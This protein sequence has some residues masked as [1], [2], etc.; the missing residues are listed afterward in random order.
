MHSRAGDANTMLTP[1]YETVTAIERQVMARRQRHA[2]D[3]ITRID[4]MDIDERKTKLMAAAAE[5]IFGRNHAKELNRL[6]EKHTD[7]FRGM[8]ER[9]W[10]LHHDRT[11]REIGR[12][13]DRDAEAERRNRD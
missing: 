4:R 6:L 2:Q 12:D 10:R 7:L 8:L 3:T 1:D 13:L 11:L 9:A 5:S